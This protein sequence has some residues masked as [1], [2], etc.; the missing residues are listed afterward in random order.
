MYKFINK[1]LIDEIFSQDFLNE[2]INKN[3]PIK[4]NLIPDSFLI[5]KAELSNFNKGIMYQCG[6]YKKE[7]LYIII[8]ATELSKVNIEVINETFNKKFD[9]VKQVVEPKFIQRLYK[10]IFDSVS[11][12]YFDVAL[13]N[14]EFSVQSHKVVDFT[15][16]P[17]ND[18]ALFGYGIKLRLSVNAKFN[19]ESFI[20]LP[21]KLLKLLIFFLSDRDITKL[22]NTE[23]MIHFIERLEFEFI[24]AKSFFPFKISDF[25][26]TLNQNEFQKTISLMLSSNMLSYDMLFA[27][28]R[29]IENGTERVTKSL[30]KRLKEDFIA[31][32]REKAGSYDKRWIQSANYHILCNLKTLLEKNRFESEYLTSSKEILEKIDLK[33][34]EK[35]FLK[36]PF[37]KWM[38]K[39]QE[40]KKLHSIFSACNLQTVATAIMSEPEDILSIFEKSISKRSYQDLL[41][42]LDYVKRNALSHSEQIRA[43]HDMLF[44]YA[45]F[46][47][48][49]LPQEKKELKHWSNFKDV[50]SLN[51]AFNY[52]GPVD[53]SI[54]IMWLDE[55]QKRSIV[56]N[57]THPAKY[58]VEDLLIGKIKLNM[59]Y[60]KN[61][62][63]RTAINLAEE[64]YKLNFTGRINLLFD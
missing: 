64:L 40:D 29:V 25:F 10:S 44:K 50:L 52:V 15:K 46:S 31:N 34:T 51:Y 61:T 8:P 11:K 56:K 19:F 48:K 41:S 49:D 2:D 12:F 45:E 26:N 38:D 7:S 9:D 21:I 24:S 57:L 17:K 1:T 6:L 63:Q 3:S 27:L 33:I 42:D 55:K 22:K 32:A 53:F 58:F 18:K 54:G 59:A 23:A 60:G 43:K 37:F 36:T 4:I 62:I 47:F 13:K 5:G 16:L 14:M 35:V 20:L 28:S 39:A 30:S